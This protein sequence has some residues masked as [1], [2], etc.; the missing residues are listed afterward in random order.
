MEPVRVSNGVTYYDSSIDSTPVRT[1]AVLSAM[2]IKP[3]VI[4]GGYDKRIPFEPLADAICEYAK[5]VVLTGATA[6]KILTAL[7]KKA[8]VQEG[9]M[10]VY[11]QPDFTEA[12]KLACTVA[13]SGDAVLLSPACAS[14]D[15]FKN[16]EERG[17]AFRA[18]ID[19]Y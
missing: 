7:S 16:F 2:P 8:D 1:A 18:I 3:I 9:R 13:Q 6:G 4:C 14:F 12:V 10:P 15:A 5:A 17:M 19:Q 11:M